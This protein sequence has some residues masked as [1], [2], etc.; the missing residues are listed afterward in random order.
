[1]EL[2]IEKYF[3]KVGSKSDWQNLKTARLHFQIQDSDDAGMLESQT[4]TA[5]YD[6][7]NKRY[8]YDTTLNEK[9]FITIHDG[10]Q[11]QQFMQ[12]NSEARLIPLIPQVAYGDA[13]PL[14]RHLVS[15]EIS[16]LDW[17]EL[18]YIGSVQLDKLKY[19]QFTILNTNTILYF[20]SQTYLLDFCKEADSLKI[21]YQNYRK[22]G[23]FLL[24]F[25]TRTESFFLPY[26]TEQVF[27]Y[28]EIELNLQ[29]DNKLFAPLL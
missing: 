6:L 2:I 3:A 13:E 10:K 1:M 11:I 16:R 26:R 23:N 24:P 27:T 28:Q 7:L 21:S 18:K 12:E 19:E 22:F 17:S 8:R 5:Y 20:N 15:L 4:F 25:E 9:P 14:E 29:L